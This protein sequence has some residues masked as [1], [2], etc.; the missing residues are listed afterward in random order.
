MSE[1]IRREAALPDVV[2]TALKATKKTV[3]N[4]K[5]RKERKR[6]EFINIAESEIYRFLTNNHR[7][8]GPPIRSRITPT[9]SSI[10]AI[11]VRE[12]IVAD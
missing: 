9:G 1:M 5:K 11:T 8:N 12:H 7:K 4:T 3:I 2:P 10:G 6:T